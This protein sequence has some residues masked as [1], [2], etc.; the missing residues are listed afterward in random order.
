MQ[1]EDKAAEASRA[2]T[3]V[4][5][6][7]GHAP[8]AVRASGPGFLTYDGGD[9]RTPR[10]QSR[11]EVFLPPELLERAHLTNP[12]VAMILG[13]TMLGLQVLAVY[14]DGFGSVIGTLEFWQRNIEVPLLTTY[15]LIVYR[16]LDERGRRAVMSTRQIAAVDDETFNSLAGRLWARI[17]RYQ[18]L[19][20]ALSLVISAV[21]QEMWIWASP[22]LWNWLDGRINVLFEHMLLGSLIYLA[23]ARNRLFARLYR[24]PIQIDLF[25]LGPVR[26][27]AQ[28]GL[29]IA[30]AVAGGV[31]VSVVLVSDPALLLDSTHL[32]LYTLALASAVIL[33]FGSMSSA[34]RVLVQAKARELQI[35]HEGLAAAYKTFRES[36][37]L[38]PAGVSGLEP[39]SV[40][41]WLAYERRIMDVP[42]WPYTANTLRGLYASVLLPILLTILQQL[43]IRTW[44][45]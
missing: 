33:F 17:N 34:H 30:A 22:W 26:P 3:P 10:A 43:L 37:S 8:T 16:F 45:P 19:V 24:F 32:P 27:I 28:W 5:G 40:Q 36:Q 9:N 6:D 4:A 42:E 20:M 38:A 12:W 18:L 23:I 44:L 14:L 7:N 21:L 25:D 41:A 35:V 29:G 31:T 2:G 11:S 13:P 15:M 1:V 39:E